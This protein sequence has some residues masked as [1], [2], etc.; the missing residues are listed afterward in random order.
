MP[1]C[2]F[3][4]CRSGY[5]N[6]GKFHAFTLPKGASEEVKNKWIT[7]LSKTRSDVKFDPLNRSH[8]VCHLHFKE[9][10]VIKDDT[11]VVY[12]FQMRVD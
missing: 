11:I 2:Y 12:L 10:F 5:K 1:G 7:T 8:R 3:F 4:G 6:S 9:H